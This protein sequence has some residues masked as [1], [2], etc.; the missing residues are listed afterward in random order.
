M[1]VVCSRKFYVRY[2]ELQVTEV[3]SVFLKNKNM[4]SKRWNNIVKGSTDVWM[5]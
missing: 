5:K 4:D 3:S 2:C 1:R